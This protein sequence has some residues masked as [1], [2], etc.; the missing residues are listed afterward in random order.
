MPLSLRSRSRERRR[1]IHHANR[2]RRWPKRTLIGVSILVVVIVLGGLGGWLYVNSVLGSIKRIAVPSE[3]G[4][5]SGSPI[6]ILLVGSD[7]RQFV[8]TPGEAAALGARLH[9]PVSAQT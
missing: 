8:D 7:S 5:K 9:R 6:D 4:E 2:G 1:S 3:S